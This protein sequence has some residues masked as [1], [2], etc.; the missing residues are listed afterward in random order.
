MKVQTKIRVDIDD[1]LMDRRAEKADV[2]LAWQALADT[3]KF[4]P[5]SS[6]STSQRAQPVGNDSSSAPLSERA[7]K[8]TK[9]ANQ[10]GRA[11]LV[12]PGPYAHFL[13]RG[14]VYVDPNTGSTWAPKYGS[15]VETNRNLVF[16]KAAHPNAQAE[17]FEASKAV[18]LNKWKKVYR[19]ALGN[20]K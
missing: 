14:K 6:G 20:D 4:V 12:Y 1:K 5:M 15:K 18:N 3:D 17:W 9:A 19:D 2:I 11:Q 8:A 16:S 13:Y 7:K 10:A